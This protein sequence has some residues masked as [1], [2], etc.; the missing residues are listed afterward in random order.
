M[1]NLSSI[2]HALIGLTDGGT[3][4][5]HLS[6]DA[7]C[8]GFDLLKARSLQSE[9]QVPLDIYNDEVSHYW[10]VHDVISQVIHMAKVEPERYD[11]LAMRLFGREYYPVRC[12]RPF[13]T[14]NVSF[15]SSEVVTAIILSRAAA[16]FREILAQAYVVTAFRRFSSSMQHRVGFPLPDR[17]Q[18]TFQ[19]CNGSDGCLG[20]RV[21]V[22]S[23]CSYVKDLL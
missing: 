2:P 23:S 20:A 15:G 8:D 16:H 19:A 14:P 5:V 4:S 17:F 11:L 12:A 6:R 1:L 18:V 22:L 10:D 7:S 21:V 13:A 3:R 9:G